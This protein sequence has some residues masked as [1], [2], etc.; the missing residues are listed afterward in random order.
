MDFVG[1]ALKGLPRLAKVGAKVAVPL[2]VGTA[3]AIAAAVKGAVDFGKGRTI[4]CDAA[5]LWES[6]LA[7]LNAVEV[8]T[9]S[10]AREYG[11][12]QIRVHAANVGRFA[13]WLERNQAQVKRLKFKKVDGVRI[14]IPNIPKYVAGVQ[15]IATGVAGL[16]S[17]VG[18]GVAAPAAALWGVSTFATAGTGA[19]ISG[20]SGVAATNATLATLGGGTLAA[21]GGG[22]A[23]GA[24]VLG[25]S[26]VIPALLVGGFTMGVL[27]ARCKTKS[28]KIAAEVAQEIE[29]A[30][31][32]EDLLR[33]IQRRVAELRDLLNRMARRSSGALDVLESVEF[34]AE[35]H[36]SEFLRAFQLVTAVKEILNTPILDAKTG[37]LSEA[38]IEIIRKYA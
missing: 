6:A 22:M 17:A 16:A 29:R 7:D 21:G 19:A 36:A 9:E 26:A 30:A 2:G 8:E 31:L 37:D 27:G 13:D 25:L 10:I 34:E 1:L 5:Q 23:A 11:E 4:R 24:A 33:A 20:L 35:Q 3:A 28:Q 38:S 12:L 14:R 18:A 32:A 15:E